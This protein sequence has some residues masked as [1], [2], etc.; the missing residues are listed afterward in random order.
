MTVAKRPLALA[1]LLSTALMACSTTR[2]TGEPWMFGISRSFYA[3]LD[4]TD[5]LD[6]S[7]DHD[8]DT[9]GAAL[10]V[11]ALLLLPLALD[12]A[13]LPVTAPHDLLFVD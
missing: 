3:S 8:S 4:A 13:L 7:P 5:G 10:A 2:G 1:L 12:T 11:L 9:S 6:A